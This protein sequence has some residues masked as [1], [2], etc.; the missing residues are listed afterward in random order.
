MQ[1]VVIMDYINNCVKLKK[2]TYFYNAYN[3]DAYVIAKLMN[4][5]LVQIKNDSI[6]VGFPTHL[7][8]DVLK[9]LEKYKVSYYVYGN[10]NLFKDFK[11][12][13]NYIKYLD[14]SLPVESTTLAKKQP[15]YSGTFTVMFANENE[16]EEYIIDKTIDSNAEIVKLVYQNNVGDILTLQSGIKF[17]IIAKNI[18]IVI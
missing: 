8:K 6:T 5:K 17:I 2:N 10:K 15:K 13:N 11:Q 3:D 12:N 16:L 14:K 4:Y 9:K 7:L 18:K 1:V